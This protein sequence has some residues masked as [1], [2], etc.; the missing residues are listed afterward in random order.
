[1]VYICMFRRQE[2]FFRPVSL[3]MPSFFIVPVG[4]EGVAIIMIAVVIIISTI[5]VTTPARTTAAA[6]A[7]AAT[8][9]STSAQACKNVCAPDGGAFV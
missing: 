6:F 5:V 3:L 4:G 8:T 9:A 2:G 7:A 1:M